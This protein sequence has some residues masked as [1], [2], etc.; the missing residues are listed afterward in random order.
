MLKKT[1]MTAL[2]VAVAAVSTTAMAEFKPFKV[3]GEV[4]SAAEQEA[5]A[6]NML[7]GNPN[8]AQLIADPSFPEQVKELAIEYRALGD[9]ARQKGFDKK[10]EV[11]TDLAIM[12]NMTL[13]KHVVNDYVKTHPVT[14]S[15][16]KAE[17]DKE[18]ARWG[19]TEVRVRHILVKTE[20]EAKALI[21]QLKKGANF[22]KLASEKSLDQGSRD[23]GGILDWTSPSTYT[24]QLSDA[25]K[26][27]KKGQLDDQ[28]VQSPAGWHVVK[29]ED[30]RASQLFPKF[31]ER[32]E[33]LRHILVQRNVLD[34]IHDQVLRAK[35]EDT[36]TAK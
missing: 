3:N 28:P 23:V 5:I 12:E 8:A 21:A 18:K 9:Y 22:A 16:L 13:E 24:T 10:P 15:A 14:D 34:F 17:Y 2:M 30:T 6:K 25:I 1:F 29:L 32:K 7:A 31:E 19:A 11:K 4:V 26:S 33:E 20:A 35:V 36:T 27:L